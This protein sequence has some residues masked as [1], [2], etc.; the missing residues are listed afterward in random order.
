MS[1]AVETVVGLSLL[2]FVGIIAPFVPAARTLKRTPERLPPQDTPLTPQM[3]RD[4]FRHVI[5]R[6][7]GHLINMARTQGTL[8]GETEK[9]RPYLILGINHHLVNELDPALRRLKFMLIASGHLDIPGELVCER[10]IYAEGKI[11]VGHNTVIKYALS[12]RDIAINVRARVIRWVHS[13]RRLDIAEGAWVRGWASAGV[14]IALARRA[15]FEQ[16]SAPQIVFGR[17]VEDKH[18]NAEVVGRYSPPQKASGQPRYERHLTIEDNHVVRG[19]LITI[20]SL[21]IGQECRVIGDL[22]A[23]KFLEIGAHCN[24]EGAIYCDG[25]I[26][27]HEGCRLTGPIIAQASIVIHAGTQ[28][29]TQEAPSTISAAHIRIA[30]G[31]VLHGMAKASQRG[32]VFFQE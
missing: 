7:F 3:Q 24:I 4:T 26:V 1:L 15:R 29:G 2:G 18:V 17:Q 31:C 6:Q 32:E 30:E 11:N 25:V 21:K 5:T 10:E 8:R 20:D 19:D 16:L 13:D 12:P 28:I 27:I 22:R 23:G 14:E 9:G